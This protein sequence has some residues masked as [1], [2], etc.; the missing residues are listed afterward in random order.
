MRRKKYRADGEVEA[1]YQLYDE[2][3]NE[4]DDGDDEEGGVDESTMTAADFFGRPDKKLIT[5]YKAKQGK[6][7]KKK[8]GAKKASMELV[9]DDD[10]DSWDNHNF[11]EGG[12]DWKGQGEDG[13]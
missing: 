11:E 12:T 5:S 13:V 9:D 2:D 3:D 10:A 8:G 6:G 7:E 1:L 4:F